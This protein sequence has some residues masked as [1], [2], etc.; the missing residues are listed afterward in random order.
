MYKI[1]NKFQ[2]RTPLLKS[3]VAM[4]ILNSNS[5]KDIYQIFKNNDSIQEAILVSSISEYNSLINYDKLDKKSKQK[6]IWTLKKYLLRMSTRATPFGL[7]SKV[8]IYDEN[9]DYNKRVKKCKGI[10]LDWEWVINFCHLLENDKNIIKKIKIKRNTFIYEAGER[11]YLVD[12]DGWQKNEKTASIKNINIIKYIFSITEKYT[13]YKEIEKKVFQ[14][15]AFNKQ[16]DSEDFFLLIK[17]L[18][19][20]NYLITSLRFSSVS[21]GTIDLLIKMLKS[22]KCEQLYEKLIIVRQLMNKYESTTI[23]KGINIYLELIEKMS[24]ICQSKNYLHIDLYDNKKIIITVTQKKHIEKAV[25]H[26]LELTPS[27][28]EDEYIKSYLYKFILKYGVDAKI[29]LLELMNPVTGLGSPYQNKSEYNHLSK[30]EE[31]AKNF[32]ENMIKR[33]IESGASKIDLSNIKEVPY[34]VSSNLF[35]SFDLIVRKVNKNGTLMIIPNTGSD[36]AFKC[37][38]RFEYKYHLKHDNNKG[39][40]K[41]EVEISEVFKKWSGMNIAELSSKP[42]NILLLNTFCDNA[43]EIEL[44]DIIVGL[45]IYG[46]KYCFTFFSKNLNKELHFTTSS[47][48]NYKNPYFYSDIGRFLLT[49]CSTNDNSFFLINYFNDT[50]SEPFVPRIID[51]NMILC[52]KHW[53]INNESLKV[54]YRTKND[55]ETYTIALKKFLKIWNVPEIVFLEEDDRRILVNTNSKWDLYELVK[56]IKNSG[57]I[58]L[59][60]NISDIF[61]E[62]VISFQNTIP[63]VNNEVSCDNI[64]P[65]DSI[66]R[67]FLPGTEWV[68]LK[69]YTNDLI[70][71]DLVITE[72]WK[73]VKEMKK[74]NCIDKFHYLFYYD[75]N[76]ESQLRIRFHS[77]K[78]ISQL[79]KIV[80]SWG[81]YLKSKKYTNRISLDSYVR[82]IERYGGIKNIKFIEDFFD[83][84]SNISIILLSYYRDKKID[85]LLKKTCESIVIIRYLEKLKNGNTFQLIHVLEN[86]DFEEDKKSFSHDYRKVSKLSKQ[87]FNISKVTDTNVKFINSLFKKGIN[88]EKNDDDIINSL[89]HMHCN[90]VFLNRRDEKEVYYFAY[91]FLKTR[92]F[93]LKNHRMSKY[94]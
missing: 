55:I 83:F 56:K 91:K 70:S 15:F 29:S 77:Y 57:Y 48:I 73:K 68:F 72:L 4:K 89:L 7:F 14:K 18:I 71:R 28:Q 54:N 27:Q 92:S 47:M 21:E 50:E 33:A 9:K 34:T 64:L 65:Y 39:G 79:I 2:S 35:D 90:R 43:N 63:C 84:D 42:Q 44:K 3:N 49:S 6:S 32:F 46:D 60:E 75:N 88:L 80:L 85:T 87:I 23:G 53:N 22:F 26:F 94:E 36:R 82:E 17:V 67:V 1:L 52:P 93:L 24:K 66:Q 58:K 30:N 81:N 16:N 31:K 12:S 78:H 19:K 40:N 13:P 41:L 5:E 10:K 76:T 74:E 8:S 59:T 62:L 11:S 51:N 61:E 37:N 25:N 69:I 45:K 38:R 86:I 20:S